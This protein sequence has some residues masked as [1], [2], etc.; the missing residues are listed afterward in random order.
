MIKKLGR[1]S[2]NPAET[3]HFSQDVSVVAPAV[4]APRQ[5]KSRLDSFFFSI[6]YL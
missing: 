1:S 4:N 3:S 2:F 6:E 5:R